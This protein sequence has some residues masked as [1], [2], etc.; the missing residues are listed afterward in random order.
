MSSIHLTDHYQ[1]FALLFY[2]TIHAI[3]H[4]LVIPYLCNLPLPLTMTFSWLILATFTMSIYCDFSATYTPITEHSDLAIYN[5][6]IKLYLVT[7]YHLYHT[8]CFKMYHHFIPHLLFSCFHYIPASIFSVFELCLLSNGVLLNLSFAVTRYHACTS[9][10]TDNTFITFGTCDFS[11][12]F[13]PPN[14]PPP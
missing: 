4:Y 13:N 8:S 11:T 6:L 2:V 10:F 14:S 3:Y 7:F 9:R 12:Y 5:Y 1:L